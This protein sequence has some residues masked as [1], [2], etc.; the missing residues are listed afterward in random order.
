MTK[1]LT[2]FLSLALLIACNDPSYI[3]IENK[4]A[5]STMQNIEWGGVP[6]ASQLLPGETSTKI[7]I[8][9]D[10]YYEIDLP[11]SYP[12]KFYL[13]VNGDIVYLETTYSFRLGEES[14]LTIV[15]TDTTKVLNP[16]M[17]N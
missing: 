17:D 13:N 10:G 4:L 11:K 5:N 2:I 6:L 8:Y 14:E 16:L 3:R 7:S 1:K 9:D 15:I 12:L